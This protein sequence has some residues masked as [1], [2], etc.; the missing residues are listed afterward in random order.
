LLIALEVTQELLKFHVYTPVLPSPFAAL[1]LCIKRNQYI[2]QLSLPKL[3]FCPFSIRDGV[4][5]DLPGSYHYICFEGHNIF[6][7]ATMLNG[8][9]I[10]D[11]A[12]LLIAST[13]SCPQ[14]QNI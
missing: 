3:F 8:A 9:A 4:S 1:M 6:M 14:P 12:L 7:A 11:G 5:L 13:E 2:Y 10:M